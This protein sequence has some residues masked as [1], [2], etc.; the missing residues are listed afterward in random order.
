VGIFLPFP[1]NVQYRT[2]ELQLVVKMTIPAHS[3]LT[4]GH[5]HIYPGEHK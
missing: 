1:L 5:I 2:D 3:E 4:A